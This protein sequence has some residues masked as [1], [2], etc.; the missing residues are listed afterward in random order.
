MWVIHPEKE[1]FSF[2]LDIIVPSDL[3]SSNQTKIEFYDAVLKKLQEKRY[4]TYEKKVAVLVRI[5]RSSKEVYIDSFSKTLLNALHN[6]R[7]VNQ[8]D[9]QVGPKRLLENDSAAY[10]ASFT[11][12]ARKGSNRVDYYIWEVGPVGW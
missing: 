1:A 8:F 5:Q 7:K 6:W 11:V 12:E 10:I 9:I 3:H 4:K 2:G